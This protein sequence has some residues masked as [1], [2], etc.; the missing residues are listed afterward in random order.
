MTRTNTAMCMSMLAG[1]DIIA[2]ITI[3]IF[4]DKRRIP[5]RISFYIGCIV[6]SISRTILSYQSEFNYLLAASAMTGFFRS[7]IVINQNLVISEYCKKDE[8]KLPMALGLNMVMKGL[9]IMTVGQALG[10][11]RDHYQ[12]YF[13]CF[14]AQN[15][16]LI[17]VFVMWTPEFLNNRF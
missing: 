16:L 14:F 10:W 3:P 15:V 5:S 12:N 8:T 13:A 9:A 1:A 4:T 7:T 6:L 2:R 17:G 11:V